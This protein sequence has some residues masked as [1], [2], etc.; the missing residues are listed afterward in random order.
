MLSA[1]IEIIPQSVTI[2]SDETLLIADDLNTLW[3][4]NL[5]TIKV[6]GRNR[7]LGI[8]LQP[9]GSLLGVSRSLSL[10]TNTVGNDPN[11][12]YLYYYIPR[13]GAVVRWDFR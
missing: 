8:E 4:A 7:H 13:D 9:L 3:T 2:R 12:N 5:T 6:Y 11:N 1:P 10:P